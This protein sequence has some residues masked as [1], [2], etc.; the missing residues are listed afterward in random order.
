MCLRVSGQVAS[1]VA[2]AGP[3]IVLALALAALPAR[4][5]ARDGQAG[6]PPEVPQSVAMPT[7]DPPLAPG[8]IPD[9][10]L[11]F[12]SQVAGWIEPCG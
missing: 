2:W 12:T 11:L 8:P 1:R 3:V 4:L 5:S 6:G 7:P 9:L 10:D